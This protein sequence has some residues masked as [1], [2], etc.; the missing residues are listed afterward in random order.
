MILK[1]FIDKKW[2]TKLSDKDSIKWLTYGS[3]FKSLLIASVGFK[4]ME[5]ESQLNNTIE[6]EFQVD[7]TSDPEKQLYNVIIGNDLLY[8]MGINILFKEK[9]IQ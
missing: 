1:K 6:Y 5:F 2:Q 8:N 9:Q 7:E 3:S 4:I